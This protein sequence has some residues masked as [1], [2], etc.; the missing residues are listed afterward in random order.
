MLN[1]FIIWEYVIGSNPSGLG[2]AEVW[3]TSLIFNSFGGSWRS[4]NINTGALN[5]ASSTS[6]DDGVYDISAAYYV[7]A[8][9]DAWGDTP[10]IVRIDVWNGNIK[11]IKLLPEQLDCLAIDKSNSNLLYSVSETGVLYCH[12]LSNGDEVWSYSGGVNPRYGVDNMATKS[13]SGYGFF[14]TSSSNIRKFNTSNG[15]LVQDIST[16][17]YSITMDNSADYIY[18]LQSTVVRKLNFTGGQIWS[19]DISSYGTA[20]SHFMRLRIFGANII[21]TVGVLH[22]DYHHLYINTTTGDIVRVDPFIVSSL[23]VGD[24]KYAGSSGNGE[25]HGAVATA[26][27]QS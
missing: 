3:G 6:Y 21:I 10:G 8:I 27:I 12:Q 15:A 16:S 23:V 26:A 11:R 1:P 20:T 5:W 24:G 2:S 17:A 4:L 22:G 19:R 9:R 13:A 7:F 25:I 18:E 14:I